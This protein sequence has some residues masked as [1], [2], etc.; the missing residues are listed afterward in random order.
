MW[1]KAL[2]IAYIVLFTTMLSVGT[3]LSFVHPDGS[4]G[5]VVPVDAL[6]LISIA[7][8]SAET[9]LKD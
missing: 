5:I 7:W 9:L 4:T 2:V 8:I 1:K 6:G 3:V